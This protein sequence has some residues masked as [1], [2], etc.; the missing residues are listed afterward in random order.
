MTEVT[1]RVERSGV[2]NLSLDIDL[3]R[4][5]ATS[6]DYFTLASSLEQ[7][8]SVPLWQQIGEAIKMENEGQRVPLT[9]VGAEG[10]KNYTLEDFL[11]PLVWPK[12]RADMQV[13]NVLRLRTL[14]WM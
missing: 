10:V 6:E 13:N 12:V 9:F 14:R 1:V 2:V 8:Q 5:M 3:S 4:S 7:S 11:D